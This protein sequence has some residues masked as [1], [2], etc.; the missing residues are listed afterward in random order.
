[1][2][3]RNPLLPILLILCLAAPACSLVDLSV[4][5]FVTPSGI[6][7]EVGP[8]TLAVS[9][10]GPTPQT[11]TA[12]LRPTWTLLPETT[13][14]ATPIQGEGGLSGVTFHDYDGDGLQG[15][16]EPGVA[17]VWVCIY[18]PEG[19]HC[20]LSDAWGSYVLLGIPEGWQHVYAFSPSDDPVSAF[21]YLNVFEGWKEI[22][23][24][25]AGNVWV[26]DQ[27][28][29]QA[30]LQT[31]DEPL[32]VEVQPGTRLD[33]A[34]MQGYLSDI[35]ACGD[36]QKVQTYQAYDLDPLKGFVRNYQESESR[37][38][39][40]GPNLLKGDNHFAIDWGSTNQHVIGLPVYAPANGV[41]VFAGDGET[42]NGLCRLVNLV[43]PE[44]GASSGYVHLE[45]VLVK[46]RQEVLR[47]QLLGTLGMS[48]TTWPHVHFF[49]RPGRSTSQSSGE[50]DGS[51]PYRDTT[52]PESFTYWTLDN[53]PQCPTFVK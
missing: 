18:L 32:L 17:S 33:I 52:D 47:G 28:L 16:E 10:G 5:A 22:Q 45:S 8:A 44:T 34:L 31:I 11:P 20:A 24:Y 21:R 30:H 46:D 43:H 4:E 53:E 36:R 37:Q 49:F 40:P 50:W 1:M 35:F 2:Q 25:Q 9:P 15:S 51:D 6:V 23:G 19:D 13:P 3:R 48:C 12:T 14:S 39:E 7:P 27:R 29:P 38:S 41:V 26:A 42:W